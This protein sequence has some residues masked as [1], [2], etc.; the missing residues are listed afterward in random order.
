VLE[1]ALKADFAIVKA[2]AADPFG[3]LIF[4]KCARNFNPMMCTAAKVTI[5]EVERIVALGELDPDQ[6]HVP[7]IYVDRIV[8]GAGYARWVENRTVRKRGVA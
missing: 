1:E 7:G 8:Q 2:F 3:N 4:N 6:I 5:V